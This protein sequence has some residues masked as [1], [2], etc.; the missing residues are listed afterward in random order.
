L[1][2]RKAAIVTILCEF[3]M[4]CGWRSIEYMLRVGRLM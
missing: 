1:A 4:I 3:V 2:R